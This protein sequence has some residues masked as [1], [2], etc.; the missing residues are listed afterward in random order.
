MSPLGVG[1]GDGG[2]RC[3]YRDRIF[4][5]CVGRTYPEQHPTKHN[6]FCVRSAT[7]CWRSKRCS[8]C[9]R[10]RARCSEN[11]TAAVLVAAFGATRITLASAA[12]WLAAPP[13]SNGYAKRSYPAS[14]GL[15]HQMSLFFVADV[16]TSAFD[17]ALAELTRQNASSSVALLKFN[18]GEVILDTLTEFCI[19][20]TQ[21]LCK[22]GRFMACAPWLHQQASRS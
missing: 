19:V 11:S 20:I 9:F 18:D 13:V 14:S 22:T 6:H 4:Y 17:I 5:L 1:H 21:K 8:L 2:R 7:W 10:E 12:G 3:R 16:A 15:A